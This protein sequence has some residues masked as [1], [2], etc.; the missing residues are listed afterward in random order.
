MDVFCHQVYLICTP[1]IF[2]EIEDMEVVNVGGHIISRLR[3][4]DDTSLLVLEEQKLQNV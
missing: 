3:Y 1:K 4:A 2:R